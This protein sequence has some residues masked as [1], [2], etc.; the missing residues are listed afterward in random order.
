[1]NAPAKPSPERTSAD[2]LA[3]ADALRPV[4]LRLGR[5]LRRESDQIGLSA[6]DATLLTMVAKHAGIGVS[7]LADKERTSRPTMSAHV[8][9]LEAAGL[10]SRQAPQAAD[11]R[12]VGLVI[13]PKGVKALD[14]VRR[15][16]ND[17][18]ANR[19]SAL[20]PEQR[21]AVLA[22]L[23]PLGKIAVDRT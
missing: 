18:L 22:A 21:L 6:L 15:R 12:R 20:S 1:M 8:S 5:R 17:W 19:L 7:D 2:V 9:R 13:T 11:R 16:R 4:L 23:E 3:L 14:A 10:L